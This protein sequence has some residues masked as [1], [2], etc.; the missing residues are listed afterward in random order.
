M[1]KNI[2]LFLFITLS[3]LTYAQAEKKSDLTSVSVYPNPAAEYIALNNE[4]A[5]K[6]IYVYNLAG[7]RM[8]SFEVVKGERYEV[9]D[10]PNG[11]YFI[12]LIGRNNKL[13]T[14]QRLTKKA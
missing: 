10:L 6:N 3:L 12:Q 1:K 14:I 11:I 7:R 2:L 13:L 9:A 4:E 8:K 5:V